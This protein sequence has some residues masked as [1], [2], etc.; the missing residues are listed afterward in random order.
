MKTVRPGGEQNN[1]MRSYH[2]IYFTYDRKRSGVWKEIARYL[3]RY[4]P[5]E[6][7]VLELGGGYCDFINNVRGKEKYVLDIFEE[8]DKYASK[9]VVVL[10]QAAPNLSGISDQSIDTILASNFFEH[11]TRDNFTAC[12]KEVW[13]VLKTEGN[14]I[15]IQPNYKYCSPSYFDDFTHTL[16]F[17]HITMRD[18]LKAFGFQI[19]RVSPRFLPFSMKSKLP[20]VPWLIRLYLQ[21]PYRPFAKQFLLVAYKRDSF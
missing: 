13:R 2:S 7:S 4:V 20:K 19:E 3:Q 16:I 14:M 12:I 15:V 11:M 9:D 6:G 8:I 18:W 1:G 5:E 17:S 21:L 10:K